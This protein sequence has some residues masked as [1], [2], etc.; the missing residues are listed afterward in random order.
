MT[1][2]IA[3][4]PVDAKVNVIVPLP[5]VTPVTTPVPETTVAIDGLPEDHVPAPLGSASVM[6]VQLG[7]GALPVIAAGAASTVTVVVT[8]LPH[9]A[10]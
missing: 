9:A 6:F 5:A 2:A 3:I 7:K 4:Q 1:G 10:V 8:V